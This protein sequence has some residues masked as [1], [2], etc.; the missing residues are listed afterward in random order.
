MSI[1]LTGYVV[2][3]KEK[4][5]VAGINNRVECNVGPCKK[6]SYGTAERR[7]QV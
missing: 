1:L 2:G 5:I 3:L 4:S 7:Y 6:M